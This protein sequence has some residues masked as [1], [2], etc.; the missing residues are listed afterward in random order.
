MTCEHCIRLY[1][2]IMNCLFHSTSL[3]VSLWQAHKF[4]DDDDTDRPEE[5]IN[6]NDIISPIVRH[7]VAVGDQTCW[8]TI[9]QH[10]VGLII[11]TLQWSY[12]L[13]RSRTKASINIKLI[14]YKT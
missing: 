6:L 10:W 14:V 2:A 13:C 3:R 7:V 1:I 5:L 12:Q 8:A 4:L 9:V 11:A